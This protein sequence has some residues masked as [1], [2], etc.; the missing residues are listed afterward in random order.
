MP[1]TLMLR[2]AQGRATRALD[3][4][5]RC[6]GIVSAAD[7]S[8][9]VARGGRRDRIT[10]DISSPAGPAALLQGMSRLLLCTFGRRTRPTSSQPGRYFVAA[11]LAVLGAACGPS[12]TVVPRDLLDASIG[13]PPNVSRPAAAAGS[14][15]AAAA[16]LNGQPPP[17]LDAV[18]D[19]AV[20]DVGVA[21]DRPSDAASPADRA[22]DP[23][24]PPI[25]D[26]ALPD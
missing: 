10:R 22:L 21:E 11:A 7:I 23:P 18:A 13:Q 2:A 5:T 25:V 20:I 1:G 26:A 17:R 19:L 6:R 9:D 4:T 14:D 15:L 24:T 12:G 3:R 16:D 8:A